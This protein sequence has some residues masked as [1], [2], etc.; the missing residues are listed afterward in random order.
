MPF[1]SQLVLGSRVLPTWSTVSDLKVHL[2]PV[3]AFHLT[4]EE[5]ATST[6][7]QPSDLET[8]FTTLTEK[9][10]SSLTQLKLNSQ[11]GNPHKLAY[12]VARTRDTRAVDTS[13]KEI[14]QYGDYQSNA[15]MMILI[16]RLC[17]FLGYA[18]GLYTKFMQRPQTAILKARFREP[19]DN[20]DIQEAVTTA[21]VLGHSE[22]E[23]LLSIPLATDDPL[24][25]LP[26]DGH[27]LVAIDGEFAT[28]M[29][30][31]ETN[32]DN[33][34]IDLFKRLRVKL[35]KVDALLANHS[36]L[37]SGALLPTLLACTD[38][39]ACTTHHM[40]SVCHSP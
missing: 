1:L 23:R 12:A 6:M 33:P 21:V 29:T 26:S 5:D 19:H 17:Y 25:K 28:K 38:H 2:R 15:S 14:V 11:A 37:A 39:H 18:N 9:M 34:Y 4:A 32:I 8:F 10:T 30:W 35:A 16:D 31:I 36:T 20:L 40:S 3:L 22:M 7:V 24:M 27:A 13:P